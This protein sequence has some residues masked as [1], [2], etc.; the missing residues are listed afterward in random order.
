M[1]PSALKFRNYLTP[2]HEDTK[3]A[4]RVFAT[5][6]TTGSEFLT[7]KKSTGPASPK[8]S[9]RCQEKTHQTGGRDVRTPSGSTGFVE[10][11]GISLCLFHEDEISG[12][13]R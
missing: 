8:S 7:V 4:I 11:L 9:E 3:K 5:R 1:R 10:M 6:T 13:R 12:V 2:S